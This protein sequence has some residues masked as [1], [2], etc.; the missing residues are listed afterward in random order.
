MSSKE[1]V[2][3][4]SFSKYTVASISN[5]KIVLLEIIVFWKFWIDEFVVE[6]LLSGEKY[7]LTSFIETTFDFDQWN[8]IWKICIWI[9]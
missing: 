4:V 5:G 3:F 7:E 9:N 1:E 8:D 2:G 6:R